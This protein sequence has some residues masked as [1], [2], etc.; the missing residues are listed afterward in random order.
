MK[1]TNI[2]NQI[3][4]FMVELHNN[5]GHELR[6]KALKF[7]FTFSQME[8]LRY[9]MKNNNPTM[10]DIANYLHITPPSVTAIIEYLMKNGLIK[11][12]IQKSD[13]RVV[14]IKIT[15]KAHKIFSS[16]KSKKLEIIKMILSRLN[17]NDQKEFIR[18]LT[19]LN[20]EWNN[21][22]IK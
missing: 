3:E 19:V 9:V 5:I 22:A 13:H 21:V 4:A 16:I 14:H 1:T 12:E 6:E 10:K 2:E 15:S 8:V 7:N 18:I 17:N 11:K 20:K